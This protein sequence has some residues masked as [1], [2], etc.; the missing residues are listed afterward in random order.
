MSAQPSIKSAYFSMEMMLE[1]DIPT[2][3][4][5]LGVLAG[6]TLRSS[7]DLKIPA[8]GVSLVYS[9]NIFGQIINPDG[10]QSFKETDWQKMDQITH[11]SQTTRVTIGGT[12]VNVHCWRYDIVGIDGFIV[13][14]FLLDTD[15]PDNPQWIREITKNLYDSRQDLRIC[16]EI[17]L[18]IGGVQMLR[19][20]GYQHIGNYHLNEGHCSFV[21][22]ALL[23]ENSYQDELVRQQCV[24]TT[25]T[26]IPEG[27][28][29][30]D[31]NTAYKFA[32]N[33]LPWH[34]KKLAGEESLHMTRLGVN[35]SHTAFAVSKKHQ[36][37]SSHNFPEFKFDYITNGI[38]LRTWT[39]PYMQDVF[40]IYLPEWSENPELLRSA[41]QKISNDILWKTHQESKHELVSYVNRHLTS[42]GGINACE[43]PHDAFTTDTLTIAL[44]RRPVQYKRPLLLYSDLERL[45]RI[46]AGRLQIIQCGKSHPADQASQEIVRQIVSTSQRLKGVLKICYLENYSPKIARLLVS[47]CDVWVNTP[48]RPLEASGT[49][50]MKA[51]INGVPHFSVLDGWWIEGYA[52]NPL[53]GFTIGPNDDTVET[54]SSDSEDANDLYNKLQNEIIPMYYDKRGEWIERMKNA[55][56]LGATFNTHRCVQE[57]LQKAWKN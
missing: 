35:L 33:Y 18:G 37:V 34:I 27:H 5:G 19:E 48:R 44:A 7:A 45:V 13:P 43:F 25:H 11:L 40:N 24:F 53:S 4:G 52:Q 47:G 16:Q 3:A 22:L 20:L 36:Q 23:A 15:T 49:S 57:L 51:T 55:I 28:D 29:H 1:T 12:E 21:T 26:P 42:C 32:G 14:V 50:G 8:V 46:G 38:H 39:S 17:L 41:V 31:Y 30:F 6:D 56:T 9:G 54:S 2:Y 10:T